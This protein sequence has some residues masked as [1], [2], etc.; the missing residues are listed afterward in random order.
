MYNNLPLS[1]LEKT[2]YVPRRILNNGALVEGWFSYGLS[3]CRKHCL[4]IELYNVLFYV[5][6]S[7]YRV[8]EHKKG[9]YNKNFELCM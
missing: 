2:I 7:F 8:A 9:N 5:G 1:A 6:Y 3:A 4:F